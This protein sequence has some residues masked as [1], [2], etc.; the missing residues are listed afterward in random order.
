MVAVRLAIYCIYIS[1]Q[2]S[3]LMIHMRIKNCTINAVRGDY[4]FAHFIFLE[5]NVDNM[6]RYDNVILFLVLVLV[7]HSAGR[8]A[9]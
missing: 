7:L 9:A 6:L 8:L 3:I 1:I 4:H 5:F 2:C